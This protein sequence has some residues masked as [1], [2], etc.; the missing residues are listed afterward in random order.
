M[1]LHVVLAEKVNAL[2]DK[3]KYLHIIVEHTERSYLIARWLQIIG[4]LQAIK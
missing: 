1:F 3:L 2:N 4:Q